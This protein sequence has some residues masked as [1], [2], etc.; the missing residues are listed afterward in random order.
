MPLKKPNDEDKRKI[1]SEINQIVHQR[2][3]V[4][5]VSITMFGVVIAWM[6]P[7]LET[8]PGDPVGGF[9]FALAMV[10]SLLLF[11]LYLWSQWLKQMLRIFTTYLVE[12]QSSNWELDWMTYRDGSYYGYTKAHTIVFLFLDVIAFLFPFLVAAI[13]SFKLEP[14]GGAISCAVVVITALLIY[15]MGFQELFDF[16]KKA[17]G[18][19]KALNQ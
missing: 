4:T 14:V 11:A 17:A 6:L 16:E 8:N 3:L 7:K 18:R 10:L 12:T 1:A 2:F 5:T 15:L 9:T 13:F 19:W